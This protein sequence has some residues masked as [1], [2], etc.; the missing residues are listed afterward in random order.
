PQLQRL[1]DLARKNGLSLK[2]EPRT[3]LDQKTSNA[4][5]QGVVAVCAERQYVDFDDLLTKL[6][7]QATLVVLDG[8]E[9][10]RHLGAILRSC[11]AFSVE[12]VVLPKDRAVGISPAVSKTAEGALEHLRVAKVTNLTRS[13]QVLKEKGIWV[14]GVESGQKRFCNEFDYGGPCALVFGN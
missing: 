10:P 1:I 14:I 13:V 8:I 5:H 2:F 4:V 7:P 3:L 9:D 6:S 11:A 12:G